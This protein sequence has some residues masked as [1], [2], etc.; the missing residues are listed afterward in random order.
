VIDGLTFSSSVYLEKK[1]LKEGSE[2]AIRM[3]RD[4]SQRALEK[5]KRM[6]IT[7]SRKFGSNNSRAENWTESEGEMSYCD[8]TV[9]KIR[10]EIEIQVA[11]RNAKEIETLKNDYLQR[12]QLAEENAQ[13]ATELLK[14]NFLVKNQQRLG[15]LDK[16]LLRAE[17]KEQFF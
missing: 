13:K 9:D 5:I 3:I 10:E 1:K 15:L 11:L 12:I 4:G 2:K 6:N 17:L 8:S 14:N 16:I 7:G